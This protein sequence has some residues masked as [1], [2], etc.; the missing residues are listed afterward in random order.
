MNDGKLIG[1][2]FI[3]LWKAFDTVNHSILLMKLNEM[4]ASDVTL[5]WFN[6]YLTGRVQR[7]CFKKS[8]SNTM[9]VNAGVPQ[10]SILGPLLRQI[11]KKNCCVALL[12]IKFEG[13]VGRS[14]I[15]F[16]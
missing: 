2:A 10:R 3:D 1:V 5:K 6:S 9:D 15:F 13:W 8:F 11:K 12:G 4:G 16:F 7:V 14:K